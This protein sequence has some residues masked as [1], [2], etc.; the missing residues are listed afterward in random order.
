MSIK[1]PITHA[2]VPTWGPTPK[3]IFDLNIDLH[4]LQIL[5]QLVIIHRNV[6]RKHHKGYRL[7]DKNDHVDRKFKTYL[8]YKGYLL[9]NNVFSDFL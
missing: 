1:S 7:R 3:A 5:F 8:S 6:P 4:L 2:G 9:D